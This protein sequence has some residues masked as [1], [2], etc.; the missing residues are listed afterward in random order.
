M[1][2]DPLSKRST[3]PVFALPSFLDG[4]CDRSQYV[5]WLQRK[6][7]AHVKRDRKRYGAE[8]CTNARYKAMIHEAVLSGGDRD[9]YTGLA[10]DW[11]LISKFDND[12][13]KAGKSRYLRLFGSLPTVDHVHGKDG[14][15]H[16]VICSWRVN[17]AKSHLAEDEFC[18]LCEQVLAH[19][20]AKE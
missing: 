19:R 8:S 9:Y 15:L 16:F 14:K 4:I 1:S 5:R 12:E 3:A 10:L 2:Q 17:D 11:R 18:Q 6:A 13:A 20:K 7:A